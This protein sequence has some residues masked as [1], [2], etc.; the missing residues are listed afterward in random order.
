MW[1]SPDGRCLV[2][3]DKSESLVLAVWDCSNQH[4]LL[5]SLK[6]GGEEDDDSDDDMAEVCIGWTYASEMTQAVSG[7]SS[8]PA[9]G[10]LE[11]L[12]CAYYD[13]DDR[14]ILHVYSLPTLEP[15]PQYTADSHVVHVQCANAGRQGHIARVSLQPRDPDR[16]AAAA[17]V[18]AT[19]RTRF[20][21]AQGYPWMCVDSAT[22]GDEAG[23]VLLCDGESTARGVHAYAPSTGRLVCH[24]MLPSAGRSMRWDDEHQMLCVQEG[25]A[26]DVLHLF[27][28]RAA[29]LAAAAASQSTPVGTPLSLRG[30]DPLLLNPGAVFIVLDNDHLLYW[31]ERQVWAIQI[32]T[33]RRACV[34]TLPTRI[35]NVLISHDRRRLYV[36]Q[37]DA[38]ILVVL[39]LAR[40][41]TQLPAAYSFHPQ[42][43]PHAPFLHL[44]ALG[45]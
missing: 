20:V 31:C 30:P 45:A 1:L 40:P 2:T 24:L 14:R 44:H 21:G 28:L 23:C 39:S 13:D 10:E 26:G 25:F 18:I 22:V 43:L 42:S 36:T 15:V 11:A 41:V 38:K 9:S 12:L 8:A 37:L 27:D 6:I 19:A 4:A 16:Q 17:A 29:T 35:R 32:V 33:G 7:S 34:L 3:L 5:T